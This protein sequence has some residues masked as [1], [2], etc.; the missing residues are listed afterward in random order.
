[1][2]KIKYKLTWQPNYWMVSDL[3]S[4]NIFKVYYFPTQQKITFII[5]SH[6]M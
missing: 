1:M 6:I 2:Q 4:N 5:H 3:T